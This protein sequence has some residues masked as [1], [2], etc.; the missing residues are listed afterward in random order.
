[1]RKEKLQEILPAESG[2]DPCAV[3]DYLDQIERD[4]IHL[5]SFM[6]IKGESI[7]AQGSYAPCR[8]EDLHMLFSLSKSFTAVA[9]GFA[10]EEGFFKL[11]DRV[12]DFFREELE[13]MDH[14][15]ENMDRIT[16]RHLL[17]MNTGQTNP[18]DETFQRLDLDWAKSFLA[19]NVEREPGSWFLY[20]TRA[21]YM[22][23]VL[24]QK[25]TGQK[26]LDYLKPRLFEP[27]GCSENIRWE[28]SPQGYHTGGFGLNVS[29]EDI[30][31]FG[32]F[33]KN[34]GSFGGRQLL[35][36]A[37]FEDA[38]R[39]WSD[40]SNTWGGE[41]RYGYGY[42]LWMCR[43][44]GTFR[45]DGAF[46]Q[47][48]VIVPDQDMVFAATA[49]ELDM[50]KI[51]DAFWKYI[52]GKTGKNTAD[53]KEQ[54]DRTL[55]EEWEKLKLRLKELKVPA[56]YEE[57]GIRGDRIVLPEKVWNQEYRL[58]ENPLHITTLCFRRCDSKAD[59]VNNLV[60][61]NDSKTDE[62]SNQVQGN[63]SN[64][65]KACNLEPDKES[66]K[67][68]TCTLE[69]GNGG[70]KDEL[71]IS[72]SGWVQGRIH[73]D[74]AYTPLTQ[75]VFRAGLFENCYVKGCTQKNIFYMDMLFPETAYQ[76]TWEIRFE[77]ERIQV[78][79]KRNTGFVPVDFEAWGEKTE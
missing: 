31:K 70:N 46:G 68:G 55:E 24:I 9:A 26:L 53:T 27:L 8:S 5:H 66:N 42:Q 3:Q 69:L 7:A 79:V 22:L 58:P 74:G 12:V 37:W 77:E 54:K 67:D 38:C 29:V 23:G 41:N 15:A 64:K 72:A 4:H 52:Y 10:V 30:A 49:G 65:D 17:T 33:L 71:M 32:I 63:G 21:T 75:E 36:A 13:G 43:Y 35:N 34:K 11:S 25:V 51:L 76:D 50:Q 1:M 47:Y 28:T 56:Y 73:V 59:E 60:L 16:V 18:E 2:L 44:P 6:I 48:C 40:S 45:G 57:K 62:A 20:N 78:K 39:P 61:D 14:I 19:S